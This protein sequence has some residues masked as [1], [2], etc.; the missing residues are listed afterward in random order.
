[1]G[2]MN[3]TPAEEILVQDVEHGDKTDFSKES[4]EIDAEVLRH[5]ILGLPLFEKG[6]AWARREV[7][8]A[9]T[10]AGVAIKGA[11]INGRLKLDAAIGGEGG[12]LW[13]LEFRQCVFRGGFSA[14]HAHFSR[15]SFRDCT[16]AGEPEDPDSRRPM[17]TIDLSGARLDGDLDMRGI[18]PDPASDGLL[19]IDAMGIRVVGEIDLSRCHLR[20]PSGGA[21]RPACEEEDDALNLTLAEI[22]GDLQLL[23][24]SRIEG[25][26]KLRAA[27]IEGDLWLRGATLRR[28]RAS[29]QA[30]FLQSARIDGY[31]AMDGGWDTTEQGQLFREFSCVGKLNLRAT[32]IGRDLYLKNG[33]VRGAIEAPGLAV[34]NDAIFGADVT[35][36]VDL[37]GCRIGGSLDISELCLASSVRGFTLKD[38][39]IGRS[40][41]VVQGN[42]R[43]RLVKSRRIK[44][45]CLRGGELIETL[46]RHDPMSGQD[47]KRKPAPKSC[48]EGERCDGLPLDR[49]LVQAGFLRYRRRVLH[50]D[51]HA[52]NLA[53]AAA[54]FGDFIT[55]DPPAEVELVRRIYSLRHDLQPSSPALKPDAGSPALAYR[56]KAGLLLP[57]PRPEAEMRRLV[58]QQEWLTEPLWNGMEGKEEEDNSP[59]QAQLGSYVQPKA[60]LQGEIDLENLSCDMLDDQAGRGWGPHLD[61]IKMNH[62]VYNRTT[63]E[64]LRAPERRG[65][66]L[67]ARSGLL[68][69]LSAAWRK[70]G[71]GNVVTSLASWL[72]RAIVGLGRKW[73]R[74]VSSGLMRLG[75]ELLPVWFTW[76]FNLA[77]WFRMGE[78]WTSVENKRN[79]IYRQFD[80]AGLPSS[81][82][83]QIKRHSYRSQPFEQAI[84][85]ARA[86]GRGD[87]ASYFEILK[88]RIEWSI[89]ISQNRGW[90]LLGGGVAA[91]GWLLAR[92][93]L[94]RW[95]WWVSAALILLLLS[96]LPQ[97]A[98][99]TMRWG[100]GYLRRPI[101]AIFTLIVAFLVG[102]VGV[103]AANDDGMLVIDLAPPSPVVGERV[104]G[105]VALTEQAASARPLGGAAVAQ[106]HYVLDPVIGVAPV[107][108]TQVVTLPCRQTINEALYALDVLIPLID[109]RQ[110]SRCD[111]GRATVPA[112]AAEEATATATGAATPQ[113]FDP[114]TIWAMLKAFYAVLGWLFVSL[115]I[116]TFVHVARARTE[117]V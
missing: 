1:M 16:F 30:L 66:A 99:L 111:V 55:T 8:C 47:G 39:N 71:G 112:N 19:W 11:Q 107:A 14:V 101:R 108:G 106:P 86:E 40:L 70:A 96:F 79:W 81:S 67:E 98:N 10:G 50:L 20:G 15:L 65:F 59:L 26:A 62:F 35:G 100:F 52:D 109:L 42:A 29:D 28:E 92:Q 93:D 57:A 115:A 87:Y 90:F 37:S 104:P 94:D 80:T 2:I 114:V 25:R 43:Y 9:T 75:A 58:D 117:P 5:I 44:L 73:F 61:T 36:N 41:K 69:R 23:S 51:G 54:W 89:F 24:G 32:E 6:P 38:G 103:S 34:G 56:F 78:H 113:I 110:E 77:D 17:P 53:R 84:K 68:N 82:K 22:K 3:L 33:L 18:R 49:H 102:W 97:L 85:V 45:A 21:A 4:E 60:L 64:F 116:L 91:A 46:W 88:E 48:G 74:H 31:L 72:A 83:Y 63:W 13:P 105:G 12:P 27:H 76:L 95:S 7:A